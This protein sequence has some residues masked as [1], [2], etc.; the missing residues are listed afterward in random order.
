MDLA[1][2]KR[3]LVS[4]STAGIGWAIAAGLTAEGGRWCERPNPGPGR[5]RGRRHPRT[6]SLGKVQGVAA[7]LGNAAGCARMA[8]EVAEVTCW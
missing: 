6:P 3:A 1:G 8:V 4:G 7:D 5:R 2:R